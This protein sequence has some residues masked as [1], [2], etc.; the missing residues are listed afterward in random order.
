MLAGNNVLSDVGVRLTA[1]RTT[2]ESG[3][4]VYHVRVNLENAREL[5][6][7][8]VAL[9][10]G[11]AS[12]EYRGWSPDPGFPATAIVSPVTGHDG[13]ALFIGAFGDEPISCDVVEMG[14]LEFTVKGDEEVSPGP[15][16]FTLLFGEVMDA[17]GAVK[18]ISGVELKIEADAVPVYGNYLADNYP[19]PF[20]PSTVIEY[21]IADD[22]RVNLSIYSV[23]GTL[24]RTLVNE[25]KQKDRYT[26][27]WDGRDNNGYEAASGVYFYRLATDNFKKTKKLVLLR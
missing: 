20:N 16:D 18:R 26:V 17:G 10:T 24:V 6:L 2:D 9:R 19:N 13:D 21:S 7:I 22:A 8:G 1:K 3:R 25:F 12:L 11:D 27:V 14:T 5:S 4:D 23:T 15:D